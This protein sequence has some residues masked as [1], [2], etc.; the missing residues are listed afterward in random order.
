MILV[1]H[2]EHA[3]LRTAV[4]KLLEQDAPSERL[5]EFGY[6]PQLWRR[7]AQEIGVA[8]LSIPERFGGAGASAQE[9]AVVAEELGRSPAPT[10]YL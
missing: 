1:E 4:R 10:P 6:D 7:L 3:Q 2:P 8:G 9:D 5:G